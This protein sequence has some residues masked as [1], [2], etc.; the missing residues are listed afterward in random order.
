MPATSKI[1]KG[2]VRSGRLATGSKTFGTPVALRGKRLLPPPARMMAWKGAR[3]G[4][5]TGV[6]RLRTISLLFKL[7]LGLKIKGIS[8]AFLD[9]VP[10]EQIKLYEKA[11]K[12]TNVGNSR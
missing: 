3:D 4:I 8:T 11:T 6:L 7:S 2:N 1:R 12:G 9:Q 10:S 5:I